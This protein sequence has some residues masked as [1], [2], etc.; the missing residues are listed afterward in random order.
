MLYKSLKT[1]YKRQNLFVDTNTG[2]SSN[3]YESINALYNKMIPGGKLTLDG[4]LARSD[5]TRNGAPWNSGSLM[6]RL[7]RAALY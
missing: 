7:F 6:T 3:K 5:Q 4:T 2:T 1:N